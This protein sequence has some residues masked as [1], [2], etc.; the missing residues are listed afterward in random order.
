MVVV[1]DQGLVL[2]P[3]EQRLG[4]TEPA[5]RPGAEAEVLADVQRQAEVHAA[6]SEHPPARR[7]EAA[8]VGDVLEHVDGEDHVETFGIVGSEV[9]EGDLVALRTRERNELNFSLNAPDLDTSD[10]VAQVYRISTG[11]LTNTGIATAGDLHVVGNR[12]AL[13]ASEKRQNRTD[14]NAD[15]DTISRAPEASSILW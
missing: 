10:T 14:L 4:N 1:G 11:L 6:G 2:Q 3:A 7:Q 15:A 9:L 8:G 12:V 13:G 5:R